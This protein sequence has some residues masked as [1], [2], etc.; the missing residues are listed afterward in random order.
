MAKTVDKLKSKA[1]N[2]KTIILFL[3]I[4]AILGIIF[5]S[6]FITIISK[7]D[8]TLTKNYIENFM[9]TISTDKI[10]YMKC[11]KNTLISN[12]SFI[13]IIWLLGISLIGLPI[14]IFMYFSKCFVLGF[15]V[16]AFILKY[17]SKGVLLAFVYI[18]PHH[19]INLIFYT[20]L[21]LYALKFSIF[22]IN[23]IFNKKT[24]NFRAIIR[25]YIK[26]FIIVLISIIITSLFECFITPNI[27]NR[28]TFLIK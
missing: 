4:I 8:Q 9:D 15:S 10:N 12:I 2:N 16:A 17:K 6:I 19:L 25:V 5:G 21:M 28:L 24:I 26:I 1:K 27:L 3:S 23:A 7:S 18:F 13:T 11:L 22:L 20:L 14:I